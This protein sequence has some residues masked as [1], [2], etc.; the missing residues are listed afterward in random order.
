MKAGADASQDVRQVGARLGRRLGIINGQV[1]DVPN[2]LL[3]WL[4]NHPGIASVHFDRP[5]ATH[6]YRTAITTGARTVQD[7][8]GYHGENIGVAVIDSGVSAWH[9]DLT[10]PGAYGNQRIAQFVDLVNGLTLPYDDYGHGTHVAGIIAGNGHDSEGAKAG[11]APAASLV[12]LKVLN[13]NGVG[14]ISNIIAALDWVVAHKQAHNIRV[15]NLSV[16]AGVYESYWTDPLTLAAKRAV[17]AGIVLVAA[18]GNLGRNG[19]GHTQYGGITAPGNAPWVLTVGAS[20]TMGTL[21]REDDTIGSYSSRGPTYLDYAAKPDLVAPGTGTVSLSDPSSLFYTTRAAY[22]VKGTIGTSYLPYLSLSGTSMAAPVVT[23]AVALMLQAN[24]SLTPNAVKAILQYTSQVY[25][26]YDYLTQGAGFVNT[27]G[28]VRLAQFL[29]TAAPGD[30]YPVKPSWSRHVL[31]GNHRVRGGYITLNGNAWGTNIVWGN[32]TTNEGDNIVWGNLCST[33]GCDNIVWGN[34]GGSNVPWG[35]T[36][37]GDNIVW[38]NEGGDNIVWGNDCGGADC[39]N[40]VWG[41]VD[42]DNIVWGNAAGEDNIVWGNHSGGDNIVWGNGGADNIVWGNA[43]PVDEVLWNGGDEN[44]GEI[45]D[46][47]DLFAPLIVDKASPVAPVWA[48]PPA[49]NGIAGGI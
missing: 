49:A 22:L 19:E 24:P 42:D 46:F 39:D 36:F 33:S 15:V 18:G 10:G 27:A 21:T 2:T 8:F 12:V 38:G 40:I 37:V 43:A 3:R 32:A 11:M 6:N 30:S 48:A 44:V 45:P 14:T 41:N 35:V 9:D 34:S 47:D 13:Q 16:G 28:A 29:A 31:W 4:E 26:D 23:G 17:D 25:S 20:S 1:A 5:T 7:E